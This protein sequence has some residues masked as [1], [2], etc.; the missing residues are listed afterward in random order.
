MND[1]AVRDYRQDFTLAVLVRNG[2]PMTAG[3]IAEHIAVLAPSEGH[4]DECW[5]GC[6]PQAVAGHLRTLELRELVQ[7]D[8]QRDNSR[9]GRSEPTWR[10]AGAYDQSCAI[11]LPPDPDEPAEPARA[12]ATLTPP[13]V[14]CPYANLSRTQLY[15][16][17]G[18][19]DQ[20]SGAVS[21][22]FREID[23]INDRARR[24]LSA[25]GIEVPET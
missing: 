18:V 8:G 19:H 15:T 25:A 4:P 1:D 7:K 2:R 3:E 24:N 14:N 22:F 10:P 11:P 13:A 12:T 9:A 5:R 6:S 23:E 21:R 20:I 17:L 16:L